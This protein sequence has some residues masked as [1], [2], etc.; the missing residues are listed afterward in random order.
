MKIIVLGPLYPYK[1]GIAHYTSLL[2][3]AL[4]ERHDVV[5]VS[6]KLQYPAFL[7]PGGNQKDY[8]NDAFK[9]DGTRY[10]LNTVNPVSYLATAAFIA[11]ER[12]DLLV[13]QW[14]H[15][16][17]A[18]SYWTLAKLLRKK[19]RILFV[20]HNVF[21]HEKFPLQRFLVPAVL[22]NGDAFVVQSKLDERD[23]RS[24][25]EKPRYERTV[26]PTY[27]AFNISGL[28]K[29]QAR[30]RLGLGENEKILLFFGFIREYK[31]LKT[32]I[33]AMPKIK[34]SL[35]ECKLMVVGDYRSSQSKTEYTE[36]MEQTGCRED[37]LL[38]DGYVP[39]NE[40]EKYF[41]ACDLVVLPYDSATQSA[42]AQIA[43]GFEKPVVATDV[44][45]LGEVVIDGRT[46]YL[47]PPKDPDKLASAV[48]RFFAEDK[49]RE[50]ADNIRKEAYRY[51]W[52][53]M[54]DIIEE[55]CLQ[56]RRINVE[57]L[58]DKPA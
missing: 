9:I 3:R 31:G 52:A 7:Y 33:A 58:D 55:L 18:P 40:V 20:C 14:W 15:P 50:F 49:G 54:A 57:Y 35:S 27:N 12:P 2:V 36:L 46:G 16:F 53:R 29:N 32:L 44:G 34:L 45:G 23:L 28:S 13:V 11:N 17:F 51:S 1:G 22:K 39:D 8:A 37:I 10:L 42:I 43:Y 19:C 5:P 47:V 30:E 21:P 41:A 6:Y 48:A 24:F 4:R 25:I 26:L 38:V 56:L